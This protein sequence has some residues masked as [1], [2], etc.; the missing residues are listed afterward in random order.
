M[1]GFIPKSK[2]DKHSIPKD[3]NSK[4]Y[5]VEKIDDI[6]EENSHRTKVLSSESQIRE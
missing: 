1:N 4:C 2:Y 3:T 5:I 6:L